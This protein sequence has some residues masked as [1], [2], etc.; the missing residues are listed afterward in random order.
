VAMYHAKRN[1]RNNYQFFVPE[2][3]AAAPRDG[4]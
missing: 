1:G 4:G 2:L 3:C